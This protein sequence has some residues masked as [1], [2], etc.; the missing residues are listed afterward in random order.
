MLRLTNRLYR[1]RHLETSVQS[2]RPGQCCDQAAVIGATRP[3]WSVPGATIS[4][5]SGSALIVSPRKQMG[6]ELTSKNVNVRCGSKR[7]DALRRQTYLTVMALRHPGDYS[8]SFLTQDTVLN[9][10]MEGKCSLQRLFKLRHRKALRIFDSRR[11][12]SS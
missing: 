3:A 11:L 1:E 12:R 4:I 5:L 10:E 2:C 7:R 8:V 9:V 6:Q